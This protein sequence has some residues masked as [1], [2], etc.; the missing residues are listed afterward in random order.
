M[1][2]TGLSKLL[3]KT[4]TIEHTSFGFPVASCEGNLYCF[5]TL[6]DE[7]MILDFD[8]FSIVTTPVGVEELPEAKMY[9]GVMLRAFLFFT[10]GV[11]I[12]YKGPDGK[13]SIRDID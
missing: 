9:C 1:T 8:G 3:T 6:S 5:P 10:F 2:T 13:I 11:N 4:V 7:L 12:C